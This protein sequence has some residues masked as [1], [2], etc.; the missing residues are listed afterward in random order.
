MQEQAEIIQMC[1]P[2]IFVNKQLSKKTRAE[3]IEKKLL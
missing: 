1:K 2:E 3:K